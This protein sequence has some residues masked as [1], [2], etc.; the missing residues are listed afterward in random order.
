MGK[1]E[2]TIWHL[3]S[4]FTFNLFNMFFHYLKIAFRNL[5][6][7]RTF[8]FINVF[9]LAISIACA[10][11]VMFHVKKELS[12][13][14][15][16]RKSDRIFRVTQQDVGQNSRGWAATAPPLAPS[17]KDEFPE[18]EQSVRF[19]RPS[20]YQVLSFTPQ[21]GNVTR[22][23]EKGG[24]FVDPQVT[25][26]FDLE[27][28]HGDR[29]NSLQEKNSIVVSQAMA[30]K[31]FGNENPVGKILH[32]DNINLPLKVT[33]VF[34]SYAFPTH[35]QF[36]YLLS[37]RSIESYQDEQTMQRRTWSGFYSFV[38]L[39]NADQ[40]KAVEDKFSAFMLKFYAPTG[41]TKEQILSKRELHLQPISEIHLHSKLEKEMYPNSDVTYVYIFS[42]S[43]LFIVLI[44]AFNFINM[45]NAN[46]FNRVTEIGVRKVAGATKRQLMLQFLGESL[47]TTLFAT[48]L[49]VL[50]LKSG[51]T[52]YN[53][54][55]AGTFEFKELWNGPN[56]SMLF[57]LVLGIGV[58]AGMYPA[59]FISN[60]NSATSFK[61]KATPGVGVNVV[62]K[63]LIVFQFAISVF[64]IFSTLVVYRQLQ[65]FHSKDVGFDREQ[66]IA[67][68]MYAG[69]YNNLQ[70]LTNE[71][72]RN[73]DI[74]QFSFV[75]VLPGERFAAR[76]F[77][78]LSD[79][80]QTDEGSTRIMWSD[81]NL[82]ATLQIQLKEGR[83]FFRQW[84]GIKTNEFLL[85]ES[86]VN[87]FGLKDPIGKQFT[88][89]MDTGVVV[90]IVKDFN[91]ASLHSG[92]DP[93]VIQYQPY[94]VN[95]MLVKVG[96]GKIPQTLAYL[97][98][99]I[100]ALAPSS[101]FNYSFLDDQ[102]NR[103][104]ESENRMSQIFKGF[105]AFAILISCLGLFGLS[106][107]AAR[108]RTKEIGIRKVLGASIARVVVLLS[109]DFVA[110]VLLAI[111]LALPLSGWIMNKWLE[112]FAYRIEITSAIFLLSGSLVIFVAL[113]TV[114]GQG[115]KAAG[116]D[117]VKSLKTE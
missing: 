16:F 9:G 55:T 73:S 38:L 33:G 80:S 34:R 53:N 77:L 23:E 81:E 117:P 87:V 67:V 25:D 24:F 92:V 52:L 66:L 78:P 109:K 93:L 79:K 70:A 115:M 22:F 91:F 90:G 102:M 43:A 75:S 54:S 46:A 56:I 96:E 27:F 107:Y 12:Y 94:R 18:V 95:Y 36:D 32:D 8:S 4:L 64:M 3:F 82:L 26:V 50:L 37:M 100:K 14:K 51:I 11:L 41:E 85:N 44:A 42:V 84:P 58:L 59:W 17:I 19:H 72:K 31:Y 7:H 108:V 110:L 74:K 63:G 5:V 57:I 76:P 21:Q 113:I 48:T 2:L 40:K 112:G 10:L 99:G 35:L 29:E 105:A 69:M 45:S 68:K 49:A 106:A 101:V 61:P 83:N 20:P 71:M 116:A 13:D 111:V 114:A 39:K 86:A 6:K 65:F 28:I 62:R 30:R 88:S 97:E 98:S 1:K 15:G 60:F 104:Y 103:L 89:D 47:L